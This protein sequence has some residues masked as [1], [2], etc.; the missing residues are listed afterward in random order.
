MWKIND[1]ENCLSPF[2]ISSHYHVSGH[3]WRDCLQ[4]VYQ[5]SV[6]TQHQL[7]EPLLGLFLLCYAFCRHWHWYK[8]R[9]RR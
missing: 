6:I 5:P 3:L 2:P 4:L 8:S 9:S 1:E 7:Y